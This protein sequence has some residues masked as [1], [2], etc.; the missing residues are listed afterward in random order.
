MPI[1]C[2]RCCKKRKTLLG[3]NTVFFVHSNKYGYAEINLPNP[4]CKQCVVEMKEFWESKY[5][6]NLKAYR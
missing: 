6:K 1:E 3:K 2:R 5:P 4:L